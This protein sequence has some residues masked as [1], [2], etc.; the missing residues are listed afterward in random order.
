VFLYLSDV[1]SPKPIWVSYADHI[2]HPEVLVSSAPLSIIKLFKKNVPNFDM[3]TKLTVYVDSVNPMDLPKFGDQK[4]LKITS[5]TPVIRILE[6]LSNSLN[7]EKCILTRSYK[8]E[9]FVEMIIELEGKYNENG[10]KEKSSI[11]LDN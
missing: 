1:D 5:E 6:Y 8:V 11:V 2:E 9:N 4:Q 7:F 3:S 10:Q